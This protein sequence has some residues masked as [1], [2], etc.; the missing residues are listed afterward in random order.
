MTQEQKVL[1]NNNLPHQVQNLG[2]LSALK[3][4]SLSITLDG[5][6]GQLNVVKSG[7]GQTFQSLRREIASLSLAIRYWVAPLLAASLNEYVQKQPQET[8]FEKQELAKWINSHLA[9]IDLA[10]KSPNANVEAACY[11]AADTGKNRKTGRWFWNYRDESGSLIHSYSR[12]GQL[13]AL[14][15]MPASLRLTPSSRSINYF[16]SELKKIKSPEQQFT[17]NQAAKLL[18]MS[19]GNLRRHCISGNIEATKIGQRAWIIAQSAIDDFRKRY[20]DERIR[21]GRKSK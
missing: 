11:L 21:P 4:P 3:L 9:S 12:S 19:V 8:Y 7:A 6:I 10:L 16:A 17:I 13:P 5:I 14:E 18:E 2:Q 1:Q 15:L 20:P